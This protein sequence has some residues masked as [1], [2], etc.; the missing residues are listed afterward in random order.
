LNENEQAIPFHKELLV[1]LQPRLYGY[2]I[3]LLASPRDAQDVLQETNKVIL[4]KLGEFQQPGSFSAWAHKFAYYQC[5]AFRKQNQRSKLNFETEL[6]EELAEVAKPVDETAEKNL[7]L[8]AACLERLQPK[9][10]SIVA[11]YYYDSLSI[12]EIAADRNLKTNHVAQILFR[13]RKALFECIKK[14]ANGHYPSTTP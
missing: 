11:D 4:A 9:S 2:I 3:G 14:E 13:A 1:Q 10:R 12:K 8:L 7:P 5:L 6:I